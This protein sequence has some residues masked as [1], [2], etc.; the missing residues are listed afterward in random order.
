MRDKI[1]KLARDS[2]SGE[3]NRAVETLCSIPEELRPEECDYQPFGGVL[4]FL[5][6]ARICMSEDPEEEAMWEA[7]V[8]EAAAAFP[9][10]DE[11]TFVECIA[12]LK[13][14]EEQ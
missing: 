12:K 10:Y 8:D 4:P 14:G 5:R 2:S 11:D 9:Q 6:L 3:V 7:V 13:T 1:I